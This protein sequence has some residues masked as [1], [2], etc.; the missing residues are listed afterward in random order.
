MEKLKRLVHDSEDVIDD[1]DE[2]GSSRCSEGYVRKLSHHKTQLFKKPSSKRGVTKISNNL[3][4][5]TK[6]YH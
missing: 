3:S 1:V 2:E 5:S 4:S 6:F